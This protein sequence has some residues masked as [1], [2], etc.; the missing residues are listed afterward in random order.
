MKKYWIFVFMFIL[1]WGGLMFIWNR[2]L[3]VS[4]KALQ[5]CL[6]SDGI[7]TVEHRFFITNISCEFKKR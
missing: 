1:L 4:R 3:Y 5:H 6:F 2:Q 7:P